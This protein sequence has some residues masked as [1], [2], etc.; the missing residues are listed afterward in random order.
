MIAVIYK[1]FHYLFKSLYWN[2]F[3]GSNYPF[4]AHNSAQE[5]K[6]LP[7]RY[8]A[9]SKYFK[10]IALT[11]VGAIALFGIGSRTVRAADLAIR[12]AWTMPPHTATSDQAEM[13]AKNIKAMSNGEIEV[14][15]YPSGS[16][17]TETS[18]GSALKNN[19]VNM[20][21]TGMHWW[22]SKE[23]AL[24]WDTIPF[25]VTDTAKLLPAFHDGLGNDINTL[26]KKHGVKIVGW[27]FYGY[28]ISYLNNKHPIKVPS[29]MKGLKMRADGRLNAAFMKAMGAVPV[30]MDSSEVYTA[31]QR[32]ALDGGASGPASFVSRKWYEVG[33][34]VT[35]IHYCPIV[36]P[37]EVN[38]KWWNGLT[39]AQ[40]KTISNAIAKTEKPN[41]KEIESGFEKHIKI[42]E[43]AG[44]HVYRPTGTN[45]K[46]W[47]EKA[48]SNAIKNYL[49]DAGDG[50][51]KML[52]D[53]RK[54]MEA[55]TNK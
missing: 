51:Q 18:L 6:Y 23:P 47:K 4:L 44:G 16:L 40:R 54:A 7:K 53:V 10:S 55:P 21:I 12:F 37:V 26:L 39:D 35:A 17:A 8:D 30:A 15:T 13:I 46:K 28:S 25:L 5:Q 43:K 48:K 33:K 50:G 22:S 14:Q 19:T 24:E 20:G 11:L 31:L 42:I 34:Y 38:L 29:D 2:G 52:K 41:L 49:S 1:P 27:G 3:V 36:Y 32:G 45:L 9:M